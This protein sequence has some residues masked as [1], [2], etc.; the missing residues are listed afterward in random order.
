[1]ACQNKGDHSEQRLDQSDK[2]IELQ[3][4]GRGGIRAGPHRV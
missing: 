4:L 3:W 2:E 1:M